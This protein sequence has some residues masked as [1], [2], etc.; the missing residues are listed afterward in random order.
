MRSYPKIDKI[1]IIV[2]AFKEENKISE[3]VR[4]IEKVLEKINLKYEIIVVVDGVIDNTLVKASKLK[5]KNVKVYSYV[6]NMGKGYAVQFGI[7]K[8]N[9]DVIGFIDAGLDID[10]AAIPLLLEY[11]KLKEADIV[12]GSKLHPDSKI[13]YPL[14][15]KLLSW[16]YREF[17]HILFGFD[18]KDTQVGLKLFRKRVAKDIFPKLA[19]RGFA[20]DIEVLALAYALGYRKIIE[21]PIKLRFNNLSTITSYNF[22]QISLQTFMDTI[23]V[24][25]RLKL[26]KHYK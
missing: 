17:S 12:L 8:A 16:G 1:S 23:G 26:S 3:S 18:V 22:W 20:F 11:M 2:P 15:R 25:Y 4:H 24:F 7:E 21:A 13:K 19:V 6:K 5:S 10:P 14:P 9:G